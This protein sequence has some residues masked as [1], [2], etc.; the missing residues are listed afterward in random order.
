MTDYRLKSFSPNFSNTLLGNFGEIPVTVMPN[1]NKQE[2]ASLYL[3]SDINEIW[4]G[5]QNLQVIDHPT[6]GKI[7]PNYYRAQYHL[8]PCPFC[9]QRMFHGQDQYSTSSR[10]DA[11]ARGYQYLNRNGNQVINQAGGRYFHPHY[12]TLDH[13]LN[14]ARCPE[15]MFGYDNLQ[16]MCWRC[17]NEKGDNN[18]FELQHSHSY[19]KDLAEE[20]LNR[21]PQL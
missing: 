11:I 8:K 20:T 17:N 21:Y 9:A 1:I 2:L 7:S 16:I 3:S 4:Q 15:Q 5:G 6:L 19:I 12:V 18:A 10:A 13:K 14:K